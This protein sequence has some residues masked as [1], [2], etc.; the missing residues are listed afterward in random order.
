MSTNRLDVIEAQAAHLGFESRRVDRDQLDIV[1]DAGVILVFSTLDDG[2]DSRVGFDATGWHAH[3]VVGLEVSKG[4][5]TG[6]DEVD[7]LPALAHGELVVVSQYVRG[8][9]RDRW[10]AVVDAPL[11]GAD[12]GAEEALQ[13][14]S[15]RRQRDDSTR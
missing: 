2:A 7:I 10:L 6:V 4:E 14:T 5:Y 8:K 15:Y 9:L 12:A 1:L 3:G 11:D 13:I